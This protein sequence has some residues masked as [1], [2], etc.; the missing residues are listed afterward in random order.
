MRIDLAESPDRVNLLQSWLQPKNVIYT[1]CENT[2][3]DTYKHTHTHV[4]VTTPIQKS[5]LRFVGGRVGCFCEPVH[6]RVYMFGNV[7]SLLNDTCLATST[8]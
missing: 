6:A 1:K 5:D 8:R 4:E 2:L 7:N 3:L